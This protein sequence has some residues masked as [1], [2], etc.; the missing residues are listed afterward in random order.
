MAATRR[1]N[2]RSARHANLPARQSFK[3][4]L[5]VAATSPAAKATY[6]VVGSIG[7]AALA[8]A[9]FGPKRFEREVL[10]PVQSK[11]SDQAAQIWNDSKPLREQIGRLFDRA[12]S[13]SGR[14]K[15]VRSFQSWVGHFKAT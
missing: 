15:L 3:T 2:L 7:L 6:A 5:M 9:I 1:K 14:E 4:Q 13:E 11:V 12:Q 10:K 8:I